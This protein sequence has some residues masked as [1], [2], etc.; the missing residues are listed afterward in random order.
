M[1]EIIEIIDHISHSSIHNAVVRSVGGVRVIR[2]AITH[3]V[4]LWIA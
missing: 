2:R 3:I 4:R 1:E